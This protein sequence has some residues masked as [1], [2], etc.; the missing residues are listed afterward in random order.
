M[1]RQGFINSLVASWKNA[2]NEKVIYTEKKKMYGFCNVNAFVSGFLFIT[3]VILYKYLEK[4]SIK[5]KNNK[6]A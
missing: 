1:M 4:N 3:T 5:D 2:H 6:Y